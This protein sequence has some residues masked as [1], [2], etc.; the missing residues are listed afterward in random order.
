MLDK[1]SS[2]YIIKMILAHL[3]EKTK[4][5]LVRYNK[6]FQ[7]KININIVNYK[8]K[9]GRYIIYESKKK[10]KEYDSYTDILIYEGEYLNELKNGKGKEYYSNGQ[11]KFEG[12]YLKGKRNGE[13]REYDHGGLI[14]EGTYINGIKNGIGKEFYS[15]GIS[16]F[17]INN[18]YEHQKFMDKKDFYSKNQ[19]KFYGLYKNGK[20]WSGIWFDIFNNIL[21]E[22]KDGKGLVKEYNEHN[23]LLF[24][25]QYDNGEKNGI[26]KEYTPNGTLLFEGVYLN[27]KKW[28]GDSFPSNTHTNG[29]QIK[30]GEGLFI[31]YDIQNNIINES[32]YINGERNGN[33]KEIIP[34]NNE[35]NFITLEERNVIFE[36]EYLNNKR[37][38]EGK[39]YIN[40]RLV[41]KGKY[42]NGEKNGYGEEYDSKGKVIFKGEYFNG[43]K[44]EGKEFINDKLEFEGKYL[45]DKK[46]EGKGFD[47][48]GKVIYKLKNGNG[49]VKEYKNGNLIFE[50]EYLNGKRNGKGKEFDEFFGKIIFEGEYLNGKR[51]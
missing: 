8:E 45:F 46:F 5:K 3:K 40:S 27:G 9:S 32:F 38:G 48:T 4:L 41:F 15:K 1:V 18:T 30:D 36:G 7:G 31:E 2:L 29:L 23:S 26:G 22:L 28:N 39:E 47:E 37:N 34:V 51:K 11:L 35:G 44:K 16:L 10:G 33:G 6:L 50:G 20:K 21:Y 49:K 12:E 19:L 24:D 25:G 42:L 43:H 17:N 14:F 13:G